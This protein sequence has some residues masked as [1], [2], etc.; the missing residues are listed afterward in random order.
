MGTRMLVSR[1]AAK[2]PRGVKRISFRQSQIHADEAYAYFK[3]VRPRLYR[4]PS[5]RGRFVAIRDRQIV[6]VDGD[7]F[8]LYDRLVRQ[9]PDHRFC[10]S[11]VLSEIPTISIDSLVR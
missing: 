1:F 10:I 6:D 9:F 3:R 11:Q 7:K 8:V 5:F 4:N 2:P